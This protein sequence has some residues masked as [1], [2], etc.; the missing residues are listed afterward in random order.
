M[1][2]RPCLKC[3]ILTARGSRCPT[4]RTAQRAKYRGDWPQRSRQAVAAHVAAHG[5]NCPGWGTPPHPSRDLTLDHQVGV[6]CREC[7]AR[8]RRTGAS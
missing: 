1:P 2:P 8:K 5:W 4:C 6:L 7:N 3:G